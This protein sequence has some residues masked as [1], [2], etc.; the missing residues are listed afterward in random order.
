MGRLRGAGRGWINLAP[1]VPDEEEVPMPGLFSV[2]SARG[3]AVPLC[4]W[5]GPHEKRGQP[6]PAQLGIQHSTGTRTAARLE[7][8]GRGVP[9]GWRVT[10]DHP[11]RG[12]VVQ[13][14]PDASD[15]VVLG[16][17][18]DAGQ[19]LCPVE[20]TGAWIADVF[21]DTA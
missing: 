12:L 13:V 14:A 4:T 19:S 21:D 17:L 11:R 2:L 10:Q 7:G 1:E 9:A 20:T 3:P 15:Q 8:L 18:L 6:R 5:V 16:W